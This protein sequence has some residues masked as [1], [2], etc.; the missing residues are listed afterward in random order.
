LDTD[1]DLLEGRLRSSAAFRIGG[2]YSGRQTLAVPC[3][4]AAREIASLA[5]A[6]L[7][8]FPALAE[9]PGFAQGIGRFLRA[10]GGLSRFSYFASKK[11]RERRGAAQQDFLS[12][13][14]IV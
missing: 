6:D 8:C 14:M 13:D 9:P 4:E 10:L 7:R 11:N 5:S 1:T 3:G 12:S 2:G